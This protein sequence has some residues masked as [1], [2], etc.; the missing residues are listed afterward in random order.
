M[1]E[2]LKEAE[3]LAATRW[4]AGILSTVFGSDLL[5]IAYRRAEDSL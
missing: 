5:Q 4:A 3:P 1:A 2:R